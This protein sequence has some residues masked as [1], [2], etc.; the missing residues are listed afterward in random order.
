MSCIVNVVD[1][2]TFE[3]LHPTVKLTYDKM[4]NVEIDI[5]NLIYEKE[6]TL[7][8]QITQGYAFLKSSEIA[9]I[10]VNKDKKSINI[11]DNIESII[12]DLE[13]GRYSIMYKINAAAGDVGSI[14]IIDVM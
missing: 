10:K 13:P 7:N 8:R 5:S 1:R 11:T 14:L 12:Q 2:K 6:I 4:P 9:E 3:N